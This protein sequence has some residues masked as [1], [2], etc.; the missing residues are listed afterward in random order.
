MKKVRKILI[1]V[2]VFIPI[3]LFCS[4]CNCSGDNNSGSGNSDATY[5]VHFI[6]NSPVTFN[7]GPYEVKDGDKLIEPARP[8]T[9]EKVHE[10]GYTYIYSFVGWYQDAECTKLWA[11]GDEV[12]SNLTLFAKW[13]VRN[14]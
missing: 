2:L 3:M 4:G 7:I 9:F 5:S 13:D 12:H 8:S 1:I 14:K 11:F 6:T 10:D